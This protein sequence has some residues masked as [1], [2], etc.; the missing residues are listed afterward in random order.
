MHRY[1]EE[2]SMSTKS[3]K[4]K[5]RSSLFVMLLALLVAVPGAQAPVTTAHA[6]T[7]G[8]WT[9]TGS[10]ATPRSVHR[11]LLLLNGKVLAIGDETANDGSTTA[12]AELYDSATGIWT[13]AGSMS[14]P[15]SRHIAVV[16]Q[17]G[18]VLVAGGRRHVFE[19]CLASAET[20]DPSTN[21][22][23]LT[24][25][26]SICR[27]NFD[28][29][30]LPDGRVL[31][32]GGVSGDD[33]QGPFIVK[34]AEVYDPSTGT[35]SPADHMANSR[36]D[37]KLISLPSGAVLAAG[38]FNSGVNYATFRTAEVYNPQ[39][40]TWSNT[41][42]MQ[43][44]RSTF[45]DVVLANGEVLVVGGWS[46]TGLIPT[47]A[48]ELYDPATGRWTPTGNLA[49]P[50]GIGIATLLADG[51][52]LVA[53][54]RGIGGGLASAELYESALGVWS[55]AG[56]MSQPRVAHSMTTLADGRVLVAGGSTGLG[57][58]L[59]TAELYTP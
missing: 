5:T 52:V 22:W 26:M 40:G 41:G 24:G 53:G 3:L 15:R 47:A 54:G 56:N 16:L 28:A 43:T 19:G 29:A 12:T 14:T 35:W 50:R 44:A 7:S 39:T 42:L 55:S 13:S 33:Q 1:K 8:T 49:V 17:D 38:G 27:D 6:S 58:R 34:S 57:G 11:A 10:M 59:A 31:V 18:R 36:F 48:A 9:G 21:S 30:M 25:S 51:R 45:G 37:H 23:S 4:S 46:G 32:A 20:Y 2:G